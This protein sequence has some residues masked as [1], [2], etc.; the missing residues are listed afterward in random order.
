MPIS[1]SFGKVRL[2]LQEALE[3]KSG[4]LVPLNRLPDDPIELRVNDRVVAHGQIVMIDGN[5][6]IRIVE[7]LS[8]AERLRHAGSV[9]RGGASL[10]P[11][12]H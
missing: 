5:Y 11:G 3:L 9:Q 12:T 6:A 1:I 4:S 7:L 2:P 10:H 8:R